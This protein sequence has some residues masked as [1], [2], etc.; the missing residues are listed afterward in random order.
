M[1]KRI[2]KNEKTDFIVN[3]KEKTFQKMTFLFLVL[4][5]AAFL[6][7]NVPYYLAK[8]LVG[9]NETIIEY[10]IKTGEAYE[11]LKILPVIL[12]AFGFFGFLVLLISVT[13]KY[14]KLKENLPLTLLGGYLLICA[15]STVF[16]YDRNIALFGKDGRYE[17]LI[18][19]IACAGLFAAAS[20]LRNKK[21]RRLA[22]DAV[23]VIAVINSL[24]GICQAVKPL[25]RFVPSFFS[26]ALVTDIISS[27]YLIANGFAGS[28]F[29]LAALCVMAL[30]ISATGIMYEEN[31]KKRIFYI[32]A[33]AVC[34][35]AGLM[36]KTLAAAI[37]IAA[38]VLT[39]A[40]IEIIRLKSGHALWK[41]GF[42]R[43]PLGKLISSA[44]VA[45]IIFIVF[46]KT[47]FYGFFETY[48][49]STDSFSRL[50]ASNPRYDA[51]GFGFYPL[52]WKDAAKI[53]KDNWLFGTGPD[54][55]GMAKYGSS[56]ILSYAGSTDRAYNEYLNIAASTGAVSLVFWLGFLAASFKNG[57]K[58]VSDFFRPE[59]DY[60]RAGIF[61]ACIAYAVQAFF[62]IS[63]ITVTPFFFILLG[64]CVG[65]AKNAE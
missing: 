60:T 16:A 44:A 13:K 31:I 26:E 37:G 49:V 28:P 8:G 63:A 32:A 41:N 21:F 20:Q 14:F 57:A 9:K 65:S 61:T 12:M 59:D 23:V 48:I 3:M 2:T 54:C 42:F 46:Y 51:D 58:R 5:S 38:V 64:L 7:G 29:A 18:A 24:L 17:G 34:F 11:K 53:F 45:V 33:S 50:F 40:V 6:L 47:G 10:G 39:A 27:D 1:P 4:A 15:V 52:V 35:A 19:L 36:T 25:S 22:A 55:I 30:G 43:N 62:N 56:D